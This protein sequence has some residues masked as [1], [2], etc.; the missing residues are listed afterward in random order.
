MATNVEVTDALPANVAFVSAAPAA[1]T[2]FQATAT[3][4]IWS[5]PSIAPGQ[6][7]VLTLVVEATNTSVAFNTATITHSDVWDPNDRN[8]S[9]RTPA[10]SR[11]PA[12]APT[13]SNG[14]STY[15]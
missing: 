11:P 5:V 12:T 3:G 9:A 4:G 14:V 6:T 8:D 7:L 13:G 1:G 10:N 15:S 2:R